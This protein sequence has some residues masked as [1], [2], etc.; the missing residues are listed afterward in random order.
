MKFKCLV[1]LTLA[2]LVAAKPA[3]EEK[4]SRV[5]HTELSDEEH[6][7][8]DSHNPDYDHEAFLGEDEAEEFEHLPPE[9]SKRRLG[10]IVDKMDSD[11]DGHVTVAELQQWIE[12]SQK[13][14][15]KDDVKR[16]WESHNPKNKPEITWDEYKV[17][18]YGFLD[19]E[20]ADTEE[21]GDSYAEMQR[22]DERRWGLADADANSALSL[23]EFGDFLHPEE[24]EH[25]KDIV[26]VETMEDIDKD[27]DGKISVT[28]YIGDL[29]RDEGQ[30]TE[31][32]WVES[33]R[34]QFKQF[35]DKDGDG[36]MDKEEVRAWIVPEDYD[37][38]NAEA[39]HLMSEADGDSDGQLSKEEILDRYDVF[40]GSQATDFGEAINR[41]DEF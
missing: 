21:D 34:D 25:M 6:F 9:E 32:S 31:P 4:K 41:H 2:A 18:V 19:G 23:Q 39:K 24:S 7:H 3:D 5:M 33:E 30:D 1:L 12:Y 8:D 29:Y 26:I 38:A 20:G 17:L 15:I 37:H 40:V 22:R 35:R 36:F 16:Q 10:L 14:Y 13:R 27:K 28:E 11:Q